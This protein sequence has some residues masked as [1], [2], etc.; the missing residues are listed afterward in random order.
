MLQATRQFSFCDH[1]NQVNNFEDD[2]MY[3]KL[4]CKK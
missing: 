3:E 2:N 4:S 1:D